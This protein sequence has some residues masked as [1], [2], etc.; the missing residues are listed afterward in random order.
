[1][2]YLIKPFDKFISMVFLKE[3]AILF[4]CITT[5]FNS[6]S[7]QISDTIYINSGTLQTFNGSSLPYKCFNSSN[8]FDKRN[9]ILSYSISDTVSLTIFNNDISPHRISSIEL[10][11]TSGL[12][13]PGMNETVS[14]HSAALGTFIYH[15]SENYPNNK[16]LGLAGMIVFRNN[17]SASFYWNL[18]E[19]DTL[20]INEISS[21]NQLSAEYNPKFFLINGNHNPDITG[22]SSARIV[23]NVGDT[24]HIHIANTGN[25]IHSIHF[26]GYHL[27]V[28]QSSAHPGHEGRIKDTFPINP[29]EVLTLELVPHQPGEY[30][31]HDHNLIAVTGAN[32]YP[33]GMFLTMLIEP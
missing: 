1:V 28:E 21:N 12:I 6:F 33:N 5:T 15:D 2:S 7:G 9:A 27:K 13:S 11:V 19:L 20:W 22:D 30:P 14:I 16:I 31:V 3:S 17:S 25:A 8:V 4:L 29:M 32:I 23:G 18:K 26:H 10:G 24:I